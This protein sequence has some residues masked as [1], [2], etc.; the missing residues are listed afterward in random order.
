MHLILL[1]LINQTIFGD[2][3]KSWCHTHPILFILLFLP[4]L[5]PTYL[6]QHPILKYYKHIFFPKSERPSFAITQTRNKTTVLCTLIFVVLDRKWE[7]KTL[8]TE[9]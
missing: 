2:E 3:Y 5:G 7:D 1:E 4:P 8:W 9:W 6:P